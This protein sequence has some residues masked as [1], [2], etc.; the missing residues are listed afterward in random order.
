[1][2]V[3]EV[4]KLLFQLHANKVEKVL[5]EAREDEIARASLEIQLKHNEQLLATESAKSA[6]RHYG[7]RNP[8]S[9]SCW[10]L[11]V[12]FFLW[13]LAMAD[14]GIFCFVLCFGTFLVDMNLGVRVLRRCL[15]FVGATGCGKGIESVVGASTMFW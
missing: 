7:L 13:K 3:D 1:L 4:R 14:C 12:W 11:R 6:M 15:D 2:T 10:G 9:L 8:V 5:E